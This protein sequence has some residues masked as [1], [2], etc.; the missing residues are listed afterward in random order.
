MSAPTGICS[1][2]TSIESFPT[3]IS[4]SELSS[5]LTTEKEVGVMPLEFLTAQP[6]LSNVL[7]KA[8]NLLSTSY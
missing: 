6:R 4:L 7:A 3:L 2:G 5:L 8:F 1:S